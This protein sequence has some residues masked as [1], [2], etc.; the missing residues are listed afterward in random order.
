MVT[1]VERR[2]VTRTGVQLAPKA[3]PPHTPPPAPPASPKPAPAPPAPPPAPHA[4]PP[5]HPAGSLP[6]PAPPAPPKPAS[7]PPA[8]AAPPPA[9]ARRPRRR[10]AHAATRATPLTLC[11]LFALQAPSRY[12]DERHAAHRR[13]GERAKDGD[14]RQQ[15]DILLR[16][17]QQLRRKEGRRRQRGWRPRRRYRGRRR[18]PLGIT[19]RDAGGAAGDGGGGGGA[20]ATAAVVAV[21]PDLC[22]RGRR[23]FC[24]DCRGGGEDATVTVG[25]G[26]DTAVLAGGKGEGRGGGRGG[27]GWAEAGAARRPAVHSAA[28]R[29]VPPFS[30][31]SGSDPHATC[32][33]SALYARSSSP[34]RSCFHTRR[35]NWPGCCRRFCFPCTRRCTPARGEAGARHDDGTPISRAP[36]SSNAVRPSAAW[37]RK[38]E[39]I[40]CM[41]NL[42]CRWRRPSSPA[43]QV[44][45]SNY[46]SASCSHAS[47]GCWSCSACRQ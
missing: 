26:E 27:G 39:K 19:L 42:G 23:G 10:P 38:H 28:R 43:G 4:R 45:R 40:K 3:L 29:A 34:P 18:R 36:I 13:A 14:K 20:A 31:A 11:E 32:T 5:P 1:R 22:R 30:V 6:P 24:L 41:R 35:C 8:P 9:D 16:A 17:Q 21:S 7:A 25:G 46:A 12:P 37:P 44:S 2:G 33:A 47:D 15:H